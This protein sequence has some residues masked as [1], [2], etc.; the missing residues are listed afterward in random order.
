MSG[1]TVSF[2]YSGAQTGTD[3]YLSAVVVENGAVTHYGRILQL[4]G[5]AGGESGTASL[6]LPA[7]VTLSGNTK[8]YVFN[9]QYN[10][11]KKTDYAS[12]LVDIIPAVS[13][14]AGR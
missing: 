8:L 10:G 4:D 11:D 2:S 7:G 3:E 13:A 1:G 5:T 12:D 14:V 9:E 6:S